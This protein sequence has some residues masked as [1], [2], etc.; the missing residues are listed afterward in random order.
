[1]LFKKEKEN[2]TYYQQYNRK[3]FYH[4]NQIYRQKKCLH[5][6]NIKTE[7]KEKREMTLK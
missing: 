1:M 2:K 6:R 7:Q 5:P 4:Q 3:C